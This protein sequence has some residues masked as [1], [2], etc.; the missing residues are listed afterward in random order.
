MSGKFAPVA[1]SLPLTF[2]KQVNK[3]LSALSSLPPTAPSTSPRARKG[4]LTTTSITQHSTTKQFEEF[5]RSI[6]KLRTLGEARR[7]RADVDRELR[8]ARAAQKIAPN[9][10]DKVGRRAVRYVHRLERAWWQIDRRIVSLSGKT[11]KDQTRAVDSPLASRAAKVSLNTILADPSCLAY[12]LEYMERR[13]RSHL[14]QFWLTVEGFKDPLDASGGLGLKTEDRGMNARTMKDDMAFLRAT[15]FSSEHRIAVSPRLVEAVAEL[16]E[17]KGPL[18][19]ADVEHGKRVVYDAQKAVYDQMEDEDW[20][21]FQKSELYLKA[22][23][24]LKNSAPQRHIRSWSHSPPASP[25]QHLGLPVALKQRSASDQVRSQQQ[26]SPRPYLV[27]GSFLPV[28]PA[29]PLTTTS[30]SAPD[31]TKRRLTPDA[32]ASTSPR[33][34]APPR[35]TSPHFG[36]PPRSSTPPKRS[37]YLDTLMGADES[38]ERDP[39]FSD[40]KT[41]DEYEHLEAQR[42]EA[43]QA[44]LNEIIAEDAG[45]RKVSDSLDLLA[46]LGEP[47]SPGSPGFSDVDP[48]SMSTP[49]LI[50]AH[51]DPYT[52]PLGGRKITSRSV[53]DLK[54]AMN[55]PARPVAAAP[56]RHPRLVRRGSMDGSLHR[57]SKSIFA[58]DVDGE[59]EDPQAESAVDL[60]VP[61]SAAPGDLQLAG[62][63]TRLEGK[64]SELKAQDALLDGL[65]RQAELTG[66]AKE[67]KLLHR[68]QSSLRRDSR[69]ADL[70]VAQYRR[71]EEENRLVPGRTRASIPH[72]AI[73]TDGQVVRYTVEIA[74]VATASDGGT[75]RVVLA[76]HV[77]H[78]YS[79]FWE[80]DRALRDDATLADAMRH[81][82]DLPGKRLVPLTSVMFVEARRVGLEK[83]LQSVLAQRAL[84]DA[85]V[86]RGFLSQRAGEEGRAAHSALALAPSLV[87]SLYR[88]V[89][90]GF[91]DS[92]MPPMLDLMTQGL[93]RQLAEVAD[94]VAGVTDELAGLMPI[95]KNSWVRERE[96]IAATTTATATAVRGVEKPA[97]AA[98][99]LEQHLPDRMPLPL[100][101]TLQPL[102]G[103]GGPGGFT[104]P[105]CDLFIEVF[106]LK[107]NNWLRRQAIVILLQQV[108]GGTIER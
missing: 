20:A 63:I 104:A 24:D 3:V 71:Q 91:E 108:L 79:E 90:S 53:E 101:P 97:D 9:G 51:K 66:N 35:T 2:R 52:H 95:L 45:S 50:E 103:E 47:D 98:A 19:A 18:T 39:L 11:T 32:S 78:R 29:T 106:D 22:L 57:R 16:S 86:V 80:L 85:P 5:M 68:S 25:T 7:L 36:A 58:D 49:G 61:S 69:T 37:P 70:E 8:S 65:I 56:A 60:L 14:V 82:A 21:D 31:F 94:G 41:D 81:V 46:P 72:S 43:I 48:L 76:W 92:S 27:H 23:A 62:Q 4:E 64:I 17:K 33:L 107:E 84:C 34:G 93:S 77:V 99:A 44:A 54:S 83:Y 30:T 105:I 26:R 13:G 42:M 28:T 74:Q 1:E 10:M 87:Q 100:P 67:L 89:A 96:P 73:S 75:D 40:D 6:P 59:D 38:S 15:Y 88:T 55:S 12:W 102:G